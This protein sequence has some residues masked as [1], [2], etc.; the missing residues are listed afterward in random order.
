VSGV[1]SEIATS[2]TMAAWSLLGLM[3]VASAAA[4]IFFMRRTRRGLRD[5]PVIFDLSDEADDA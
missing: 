5:A 3:F 1:G 2:M 4:V